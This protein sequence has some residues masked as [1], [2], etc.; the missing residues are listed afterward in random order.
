[1]CQLFF[2]FKVKNWKPLFH[3]FLNKSETENAKDGFGYS[4]FTDTGKWRTYK[5]P[6]CAIE[7]KNFMNIN[8][9]IVISHIRIVH[10]ETKNE[11]EIMEDKQVIN[12]HPYIYDN[13]TFVHHGDLLFIDNGKL[14]PYQLL[15]RE[16]RVQKHISKLYNYISLTFTNHGLPVQKERP[17]GSH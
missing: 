5:K 8:S 9:N 6:I 12:T 1:M 14:S 7:D 13:W 16:P 4:W 17:N 10:K 2:S 11:S 3:S 15:S